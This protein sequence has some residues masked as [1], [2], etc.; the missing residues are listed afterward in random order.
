MLDRTDGNAAMG[1]LRLTVARSLRALT[2][3]ERGDLGEPRVPL[4][5]D[6]PSL[7]FTNLLILMGYIFHFCIVL[8]KLTQMEAI[9]H[10]VVPGSGWLLN[11]PIHWHVQPLYWWSVLLGT[12]TIV[13]LWISV[14]VFFLHITLENE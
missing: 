2:L 8:P 6:A 4:D 14:E 5:L 10:N 11:E 13:F 12:T 3:A 7:V 9:G 1:S